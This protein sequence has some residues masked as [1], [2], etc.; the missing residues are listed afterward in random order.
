MKHIWE[1][2]TTWG[3]VY[4]ITIEPLANSWRKQCNAS[5]SFFFFCSCPLCRHFLLLQLLLPFDVWERIESSYS[6][7]YSFSPSLLLCIRIPFF[8]SLY[9]YIRIVAYNRMLLLNKKKIEKKRKIEKLE[10]YICTFF[11]YRIHNRFC[12]NRYFSYVK[13][14]FPCFLSYLSPPLMNS[15]T[16]RSCNL[17]GRSSRSKCSIRSGSS[18]P[19]L[20][21]EPLSC[22]VRRLEILVKLKKDKLYII[23]KFIIYN[24]Y[25]TAGFQLVFG[26]EPYSW[27]LNK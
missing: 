4:A 12:W 3:I 6:K 2:K 17:L 7:D 25:F 1:R 16:L 24:F 22:L 21:T 8:F 15:P 10:V 23:I 11:F 5:F 9:A 13:H 14:W 19:R 27:A 20:P 26:E 18:W